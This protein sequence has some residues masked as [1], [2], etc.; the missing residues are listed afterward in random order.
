MLRSLDHM[1][2]RSTFDPGIRSAFD[3][4]EIARLL[5]EF[6]FPAA[7][8]ESL[9]ELDADSFDSF[10]RQAYRWILSQTGPDDAGPD[11]WPTQGLPEVPKRAQRRGQAA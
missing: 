9:C 2:G 3:A 5:E 10:A 6:N 7:A 1:L 11:P 8:R 4:G